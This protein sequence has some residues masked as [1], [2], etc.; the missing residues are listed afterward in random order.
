MK[1][2]FPFFALILLLGTAA[3]PTDKD[4]AAFRRPANEYRPMPFWHLNGTLT[5]DTIVKQI[6][7]AKREA[8]F[9]GIA[10]LPVSG[11]RPEYL[12]DAYFERYDDMIE[13][14]APQRHGIDHLRRHRF[15]ER[16]SRRTTAGP[17][18]A[19]HAQAPRE[20]RICHY[21]PR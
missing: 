1:R 14:D 5:R 13:T 17:I 8:G 18:S 11:T 4:A 6:N 21:R 7:R 10:V 15:P 2:L 16:Y 19:R 12:T 9:G 3:K 20:G